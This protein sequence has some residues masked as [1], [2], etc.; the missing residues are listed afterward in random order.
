MVACIRSGEGRRKV[1]ARVL[2]AAAAAGLAAAGVVHAA[3]PVKV[4][5]K[6]GP[7]FTITFGPKR[8][9]PGRYTFVIND[10][11]SIHNWHLRGPGVNRDLTAV[12]A[13]GQRRVTLVLRRGLYTF[14]C[15][16]HSSTMRGTFRVG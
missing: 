6:V 7:G 16:P 9:K 1:R 2:A 4:F 11:S 3:T 10:R 5:G 14:F 15:V 8:L 12:G 13:T